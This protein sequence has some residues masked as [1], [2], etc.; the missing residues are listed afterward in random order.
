MDFRGPTE[1]RLV[2][3]YILGPRVGS[4]SFAVVWRSRHRKSGIEVAVKEIDKKQLSTKISESL[5]KEISILSTIDH[6]NIIR[7]FEAIETE[8]K[9]Y[10]VL[11]YCDGGDLAA[12]INRH[13]RVTEAVARHFMRQ[14]AEGLQVLQERHLIHRDLKPQNLLLSTSN[15][16]TPLLKIG[17]FGF[18]RSLMPQGLADTLCGSPLYMAPEI[19]K[20]K[21]YD[22]KADLWSVGAILFQLVTGRPPFDGNSQLQLFQNILTSTELQFP[23][24]ALE[25]LHPDCVDLCRC[26]L[27]QN[28][29]ERLTFKELFSHKFLGKPRA[30]LDVKQSSL[31]LPMESIVEEFNSSASDKG[32]DSYSSNPSSKLL[33]GHDNIILQRKDGEG[34]SSTRNVRGLMPNVAIDETRKSIEQEPKPSD[35]LQV[36]DSMESIEKEYVLVNA[37]FALSESISYYLETSLKHNFKTG[38]STNSQ[39]QNEQG[40]PVIQAK[41]LAAS[42]SGVESSP[43][44]GPDLLPTSIPSTILREVQGL[45]ILHPSTRLQLLHQYVQ[46]LTELS[47]EKITCWRVEKD[48][49]SAL[50]QN[51]SA[52][53]LSY[54]AGF[55]L[56]SFSTELVVL[57]IWKEVLQTCNVWLASTSE[58]EASGSST[59]NDHK[60]DQEGAD[61]PPN[62]E[63]NPDF[64]RPSCVS[65]WAEKSFVVAVYRAEKL[66]DHIRNMDGTAEMPDAME[67]IF[68]KALAFGTDGAVDEFVN[69]STAAE[70]YSKALLLL[71]FIAGEATTLSLNPPF[72]LTPDNKKRIQQYIMNLHSRQTNFLK[73]Q[74][75]LKQ[76]LDSPTK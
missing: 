24:G 15:S 76:F 61:L 34:T 4:G 60:L 1:T 40:R 33:I 56:E 35:Q 22:A 48:L 59:A 68:R 25:E 14:L 3:D 64:S 26:L 9:I 74:P 7:L 17:D 45:S 62:T 71:F 47:Q 69:K 42:S 37:N 51:M 72:S 39:K 23:T 12:Y 18:A 30:M 44:H 13:G 75:S 55:Y 8:E 21:K 63:G 58:N 70:K 43:K 28:P 52:F 46:V 36:S 66:S 11:E 49:R 38:V 73:A 31:L 20:N 10:L 6:P 2:G 29:V 27:R 19:I 41:E 32:L 50:L 53:A 65:L 5:L 57:A 67:I 16:S 54:D